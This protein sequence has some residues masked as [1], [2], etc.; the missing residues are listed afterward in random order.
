MGDIGMDKGALSGFVWHK[1][2]SS[3]CLSWTLQWVLW[4]LKRRGG[5]SQTETVNF[6]L[7]CLADRSMNM[8]SR[9][10]CTAQKIGIQRRT[11][12]SW[13]AQLNDRGSLRANLTFRLLFASLSNLTWLSSDFSSVANAE[14]QHTGRV[15]RSLSVVRSDQPYFKTG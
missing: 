11:C 7:T 10:T 14:H 9:T 4:F 5:S 8:S 1:L 3:G 15:S 13:R 2:R 6:S 12:I